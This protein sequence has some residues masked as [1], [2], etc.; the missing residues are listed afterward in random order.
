M[1]GV[2]MKLLETL[3][4]S[5]PKYT[6]IQ[7]STKKKITF[8]P[9][10]VKQEKVLL[11]SN[12]TGNFD[13]FLITL[14]DVIDQCFEIKDSAKK[15]PLFDVEHFFIKLR[16]K[17]IGEMVEPKFICPVT[18]ETIT[19]TLNLDEIEPLFNE[20]HKTAIQVSD[21]IVVTMKYPTIDYIIKNEGDYYDMIIDCIDKIETKDELIES[22]N[23]SRVVIEQFIDLLTQQ[24]FKKL[25]E[26]FKTMPK[27]QKE[28]NYKTSDGIERNITFKGLRDFFQ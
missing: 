6:T 4:N 15:L 11:M 5:L 7:P 17:S 3:K 28:I 16:A 1:K 26:F 27:I 23:I 13:D 8:K 2:T 21:K 20:N 14:C 22:T 12:Q 19:V 18:K 25:V 10:T 9:F 24:Q